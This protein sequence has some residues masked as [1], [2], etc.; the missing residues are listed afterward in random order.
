M[1]TK[2]RTTT[3]P[4]LRQRIAV[5]RAPKAKAEAASQLESV[6]DRLEEIG[7]AMAPGERSNIPA[8]F[9]KNIEHYLYGSPKE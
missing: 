6:L 9:A 7:E 8:D 2:T 5:T 4:T 1:T 3:I